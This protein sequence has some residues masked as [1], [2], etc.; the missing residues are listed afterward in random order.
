MENKKRTGFQVM[1][2]LIGMVKQL[3]GYMFLAVFMGCIGN[4][5]AT[6]LTILGGMGILTVM[7]KSDG[8]KLSA[9]FVLLIICGVFRG[10][11]RYA[12][13]A[14]NH[15]IAF[16]LLAR[17]RHQ[18]FKALRKLT[19]AKLDG[20]EKGNLISIITSDIELL[21]V[22][23]AHTISPVAIAV[24]TSVIMIIFIGMQHWT[25]GV[26]AAVCYVLTGALI[27]ILNGRYGRKKGQDY[28]E[29]FGKLNA[30]VLDNLYGI[31]EILQY[32]YRDK[33]RKQLDTRSL[34]QK[35]FLMQT[36]LQ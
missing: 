1:A 28:R 34:G 7:G 11:L 32:D 24:I 35:Y 30:V 10:V 20:R 18:V 5:M 12:E 33:R 17:I 29:N 15:Y 13:Q 31:E 36:K 25:L 23:Y 4:L 2:G 9:V 16:K 3:L 27:P 26:F 8:L 21:E 22:F 14:C 6:F 19:P